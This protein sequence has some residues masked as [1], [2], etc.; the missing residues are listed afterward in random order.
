MESWISVMCISELE[1]CWER[2]NLLKVDVPLYGL[3]V[4]LE[5]NKKNT[6]PKKNTMVL[7]APFM[8]S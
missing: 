1:E 7:Q 6:L 2:E 5:R 3:L 4:I 8:I